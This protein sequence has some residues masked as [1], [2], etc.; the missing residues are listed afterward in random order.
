MQYSKEDYKKLG[1]LFQKKQATLSQL[2]KRLEK[3]A[4]EA[5]YEAII[6]FNKGRLMAMGAYYG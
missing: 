1:F 4:K 6:Q 5:R 3:E 2:D